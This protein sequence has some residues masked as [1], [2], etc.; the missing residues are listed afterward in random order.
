MLDREKI[1][2]PL[3]KLKGSPRELWL[4]YVLK[5]LGSYSYFGASIIVT[6]Y[7]TDEFGFS[8][9]EAGW[10]Y[11]LFGLLIAIY[12]FLVGLLVDVL[13]VRRSLIAGNLV[14]LVCM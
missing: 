8:D 14:S 11:G 2:G 6:K 5:F 4:L 9:I 10:A 1:L 3:A 13:G 7:L 12:G